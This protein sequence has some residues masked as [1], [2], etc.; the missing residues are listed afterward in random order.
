M[1]E[2][3]YTANGRDDYKAGD[4]PTDNPYP[5]G[6]AA[7]EHWDRGYWAQHNAEAEAYF[8]EGLPASECL[9]F[10][11]ECEGQVEYRPATSPTGKQFPRCEH[12]FAE[13]LKSQERIVR[14]Y[15]G[16]MFY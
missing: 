4:L 6:S 1:N 11:S 2:N 16:Q 9:N 13:R 10:G 12:H 3:E 7:H 8:A 5:V 15:G 14:D